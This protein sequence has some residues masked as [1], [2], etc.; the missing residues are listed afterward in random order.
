MA[1]GARKPPTRR[2][3]I[4]ATVFML[5]TLTFFT[6]IMA[7]SWLDAR[8]QQ[9]VRCTVVD[10]KS[11]QGGRHASVPWYVLIETSDCGTVAYRV[12]TNRDNVDGLA[13]TFESGTYEFK[14]GKL[15]QQQAAG[16][17]MLF[18]SYP[19]A[20]DFRRLD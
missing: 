19:T 10:A 17:F 4:V 6:W 9:W 14:F 5:A 15:S 2:A 13:A 12:S 1:R 3:Y 8:D 16:G 18:N 7:G 20:Q 11:Q